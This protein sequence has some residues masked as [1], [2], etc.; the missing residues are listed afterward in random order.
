MIIF[1]THIYQF[2]DPTPKSITKKMHNQDQ[3]SETRLLSL[4]VK[5]REQRISKGQKE[6]QNNSQNW[7]TAT[8]YG[9]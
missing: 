5:P 3:G 6:V 9:E 4:T 1:H 7:Y 8:P 2:G